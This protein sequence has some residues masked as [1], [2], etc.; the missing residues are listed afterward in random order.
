MAKLIQ[1]YAQIDSQRILA[2]GKVAG[3]T[4]GAGAKR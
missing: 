4:R 1:L 2:E 3:F